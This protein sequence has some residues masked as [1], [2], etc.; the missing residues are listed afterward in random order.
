MV[1][2]DIQVL[3]VTHFFTSFFILLGCFLEKLEIL[4]ERTTLESKSVAA[5][6]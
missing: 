1:V 6:K 2:I 4:I 5:C 3:F